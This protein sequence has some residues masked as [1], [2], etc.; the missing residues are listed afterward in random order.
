MAKELT[1]NPISKLDLP[2][3]KKQVNDG[4][5]RVEEVKKKTE[6]FKKESK[7]ISI[8]GEND[9]VGYEATKNFLSKVRPARTGLENE[10]KTCVK[11][12]ND[13]VDAVNSSY[14]QAI[15]ELAEIESPHKKE[16]EEYEEA[17]EKKKAE[18]AAEKEKIITD[19]INTLLSS[20]LE[21]DPN[22][23]YYKNDSGI[24]VTRTDIINM[25]DDDFSRLTERVLE[26]KDEKA[27]EDELAR[28]KEIEEQ[29][30]IKKRQE[31]EKDRI[32]KVASVGAS[33]S[34]NCYVL[35]DLSTQHN[36]SA[37]ID[38]VFSKDE[39]IF[40]TIIGMFESVKKHNNIFLQKQKDDAAKLK[41]EQEK[42]REQQEKNKVEKISL[43][44]ERLEAYGFKYQFQST[45]DSSYF[46]FSNGLGNVKL[47]VSE[48][49][50]KEESVENA[51][52]LAKKY[53][54]EKEQKEEND[55]KDLAESEALAKKKESERKAFAKEDLEI[56]DDFILVLE[57]NVIEFDQQK[58]KMLSEV[59]RSLS[60]DILDALDRTKKSISHLR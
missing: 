45:L 55:K 29:D 38:E 13:L 42:V 28:Q 17:I 18:A 20:G 4:L 50:T 58:Y 25:K 36:V 11:P 26:R 10:R 56:I 2:S 31:F 21:Y 39:N 12:F 54:T 15:A 3:L 57:N 53:I 59:V 1:T 40:D 16:K 32:S 60:A 9:K 51:I 33:L 48:I 41:E 27:K 6:E 49:M 30:R 5:K 24:S 35:F 46:E 22:N 52:G 23:G 8:S 43:L 7:E 47:L 14:K 34:D 44:K 37:T 19:K